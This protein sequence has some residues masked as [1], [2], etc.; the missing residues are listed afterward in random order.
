MRVIQLRHKSECHS[1]VIYMCNFF[2]KSD[3]SYQTMQKEFNF[4][5]IM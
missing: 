5:L 2:A 1:L 4:L 3:K